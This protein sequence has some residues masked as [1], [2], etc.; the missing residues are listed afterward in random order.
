MTVGIISSNIVTQQSILIG[1]AV[2]LILLSMG[3]ADRFNLV[4]EE[5]LKFQENYAQDLKV[6]VD[7][8]TE[9]IK[10][11]IENLGQ[12]FMVLD[13]N[14]I[15]Q[16]GATQITKDFFNIDPVG[17]NLSEVLSLNEE[18]KDVLNRWI[19][20]IWRG[21]LSFKDLRS[22]GPQSF[23]LD[24]RYIDLDYKPIYVKGS[25]RKIDK[26]ICVATD[27]TQEMAL[28]RQLE[29]DRSFVN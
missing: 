3:L 28:E 9:S 4:Q 21:I 18:K 13:K 1:F 12:G 2:E 15:I 23:E 19:Q 16:E 10:G 22:L 25:K 17:K 8:K 26:V 24:G 6:E 5:N 27:K 14:G 29:L 11:L 7:K 20:N